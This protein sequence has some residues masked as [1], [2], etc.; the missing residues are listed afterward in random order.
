MKGPVENMPDKYHDM[1]RMISDSQ[2]E[3][4]TE[5]SANPEL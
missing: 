5:S 3:M 4:L 2:K 1:I